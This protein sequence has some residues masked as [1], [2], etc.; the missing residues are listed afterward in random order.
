M[1]TAIQFFGST[2]GGYGPLEPETINT[3]ALMTV[4]PDIW[5]ARKYDRLI[6]GIKSAS[7]LPTGVNNLS[8]LFDIIC[9]RSAH[10]SQAGLLNWVKNSLHTTEVNNPIFTTNKGFST[11]GGTNYLNTNFNPSTPPLDTKWSL[12]DN[13]AVSAYLDV[14]FGI[15]SPRAMMGS[16]SGGTRY[17]IFAGSGAAFNLFFDNN[18]N[19]ADTIT[20]TATIENSL[21]FAGMSR[22]NPSNYLARVNDLSMVLP[23]DST[24]TVPVHPFFDLAWSSTS[25]SPTSLATPVMQSAVL[26]IGKSGPDLG[27]L[28]TA[29]LNYIKSL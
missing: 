8:T 25:G 19:G 5:R 1:N 12:N 9:I 4:Q 23:G 18:R 11:G 17:D 10:T 29:V 28:Y 24:T 16:R 22:D 21:Y 13:L 20:S 14:D 26:L 7:G 2:I 27:K 15:G 6:K 3:L